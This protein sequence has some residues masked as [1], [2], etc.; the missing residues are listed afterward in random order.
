MKD[1]QIGK[2]IIPS[3]IVIHLGHPDEAAKN[4]TV[5]FIEYIKNVASSEIYPTWPEAALRANILVQITFVLNRVYNEWYPSKGY[6]FDITNHT[7]FDQKFIE[8]RE[9]FDNISKIVDEI[10]N[11]YIIKDDH[12]QPFFTEYCDGKQTQC[13]GLSQ[14]GTVTLAE[15]GK[16]PIE[17]LRFYYG[18]DIHIITDAEVSVAI[19]TYPGIPLKLGDMNEHIR[20]LKR[21]LN[22]IA[23]NYPAL[24]IFEPIHEYY[25]IIMEQTIRKFQE[26]FNLNSTGIVDKSTWYKIKYLYTSVKKLSELYTEGISLEDTLLKYDLTVKV[27]EEG[28]RIRGLHY[29]LSV[30]AYF[31]DNIPILKLDSIYNENTKTM[32]IA[33]QNEYGLPGTGEVDTATWHKLNEVYQTVLHSLPE[34]VLAYKDEIYPGR[35]LSLG[36]RGDDVIALKT[37]LATM[38]HIDKDFPKVEISDCYDSATE[39]AI[40]Y[41][42]EKIHREVTGV[43]GPLEWREVVKLSKET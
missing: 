11:N 16:V 31:D 40:K 9:I 18:D 8:N 25:D 27:G 33:F 15:N 24:P 26:I 5:S 1:R 14:W 20:V 41:I 10:F 37:M 43:T 17:I 4:M 3:S 32:V 21:Q 35:F 38:A 22:R 2:P 30:I 42:Q 19:A 39:R 12:I 36:M 13:K 7:G 23:Q 34:D 29:F 28:E 6:V